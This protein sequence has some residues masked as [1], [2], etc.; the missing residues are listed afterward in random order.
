MAIK[1]IWCFWIDSD[2]EI[3]KGFCVALR[4]GAIDVRANEFNLH[5][6]FLVGKYF[7]HG[8]FHWG[9]DLG[10]VYGNSFVR[11]SEEDVICGVV[12]MCNCP[13]W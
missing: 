3:S 10:L 12:G 9:V 13:L 7:T 11:V 2:E 8:C 6:L 5:V 1:L 4:S